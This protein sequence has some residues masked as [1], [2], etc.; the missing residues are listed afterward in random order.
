MN[1]QFNVE[2]IKKKLT[3]EQLTAY[4]EFR[5]KADP[6]EL[7]SEGVLLRYIA[8]CKY[9]VKSALSVKEKLEEYYRKLNKTVSDE[10]VLEEI[11][12]NKYKFSQLKDGRRVIHFYFNLHNPTAQPIEST[13]KLFIILMDILLEEWKMIENGFEI[14]CWM[15]GSSWKNFNFQNE[16][17]NIEMIKSFLPFSSNMIKKCFLIDSPWYVRIAMNILKPFLPGNIYEK[18]LFC[19]SDEIGN[20]LSTEELLTTDVFRDRAETGNYSRWV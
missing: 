11:K 20:Y 14:A 16:L 9:N 5:S 18:Y 12:T 13:L 2:N 17:R 6:N 8:L 7:H 19:R 3:T 4:E 15:E 10:E 1:I